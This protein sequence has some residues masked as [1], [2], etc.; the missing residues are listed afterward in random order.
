MNASAAPPAGKLYTPRLLALSAELA[1]HPYED[2]F[3]HH[4]E[5]R[6]RTCGS[7]IRLGLDCDA[8]GAVTR[9]GMQ[10]AACAVGQSS[11]AIM[12]RGIIGADADTMRS[13]HADIADWLAG[14]GAVPDWPDFDALL[15]ARDHSARHGALLLPWKAAELALSSRSPTG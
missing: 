14:A 10:V 13:I 11:A 2:E 3:A 5:A 8:N 6:S 4:A 15:D 9:V 7:S 12:A 1:H